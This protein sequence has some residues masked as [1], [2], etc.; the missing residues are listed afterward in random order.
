MTKYD[1]SI[2]GRNIKPG[3]ITDTDRQSGYSAA[4]TYL[5]F[6]TAVTIIIFTLFIAVLEGGGAATL[7]RK[8]GIEGYKTRQPTSSLEG[9]LIF[10]QL[11]TATLGE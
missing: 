10:L 7:R 11:K 3:G 1:G 2:Y 4:V 5:F 8:F 6:V 9:A